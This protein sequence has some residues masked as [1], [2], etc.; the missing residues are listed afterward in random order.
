[1]G[2][3]PLGTKEL[4]REGGTE[5]DWR[6]EGRGAEGPEV[7]QGLEGSHCAWP[8]LFAGWGWGRDLAAAVLKIRMDHSG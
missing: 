8:L 2:P 4:S 7:G 6:E 3:V 5:A 1:M